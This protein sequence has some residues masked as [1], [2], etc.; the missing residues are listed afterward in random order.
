[1]AKDLIYRDLAQQFIKE[2]S[3]KVGESEPISTVRYWRGQ[4]WTWSCD[5]LGRG[6]VYQAWDAPAMKSR[7]LQWLMASDLDDDPQ[8]ADRITHCLQA[9][10]SLSDVPS[11]PVWLDRTKSSRYVAFTNTILDPDKA[12]RGEVG[13]QFRHSPSW[14]S[15]TL[16]PYDYD[17]QATCP[18]WEAFLQD[19]SMGETQ[20]ILLLQEFFGY[21]IDQDNTRQSALILQGG[22]G[23][24]KS[25]ILKTIMNVFGHKNV[26]N[27]S[28]DSLKEKFLLA[29]IANSLINISDE[30]SQ[31]QYWSEGVLK[32][33]T[34]GSVVSADRKFKG[35]TN[36][37]PRVRFVIA[38]N[39]WPKIKDTTNAMW[40]RLLVIPLNKETPVSQQDR[41]LEKKLAKERAGIMNWALA[42]RKRLLENDCWTECVSAQEMLAALKEENQPH[43]AWASQKVK[44]ASEKSFVP[45]ARL[46]E[47]CEAWCRTR[48]YHGI[49]VTAQV[50]TST[51]LR[52]IPAAR[53]ATGVIKGGRVR[54][55]RGIILMP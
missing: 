24:G 44:P 34:S 32:W 28:I 37:I 7:I 38:M 39:E 22:T 17:P 5:E 42:G 21:L 13:A 53:H 49:R 36:V 43:I 40:R 29:D 35:A 15:Q 54:G 52:Q 31:D 14:F 50:I 30:G 4:F 18:L 55:L 6:G 33:L 26:A 47:A 3:F 1:M 12:A 23:T 48:R 16:I 27:F 19:I 45:T 9:M 25:T 41:T 20:K 51:I 11:M 8:V 10:S 2:R 46:Q